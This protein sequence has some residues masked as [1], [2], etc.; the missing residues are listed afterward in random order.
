MTLPYMIH[1]SYIKNGFIFYSISMMI[2]VNLIC[3]F[4]CMLH[5]L[6]STLAIF[7]S[8]LLT[9]TQVWDLDL[10]TRS[11]SRTRYIRFLFNVF[12]SRLL[13]R[14]IPQ[15][16]TFTMWSVIYVTTITGSRV[17]T[18]IPLTSLS[19]VSTSIAFLITL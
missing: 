2:N 4:G 16:F 1:V 6:Y 15:L 12:V 17:T 3:R 13:K 9:I 5:V 8:S 11:T 19:L 7:K 18:A 14:I 10:W